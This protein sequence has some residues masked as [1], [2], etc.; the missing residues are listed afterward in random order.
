MCTISKLLPTSWTKTGCPTSLFLLQY[1]YNVDVDLTESTHS[2]PPDSPYLHYQVYY[3]VP[4]VVARVV[5]PPKAVTAC[6]R[7]NYQSEEETVRSVEI[8]Q[9]VS[10]RVQQL[11]INSARYRTEGQRRIISCS[12]CRNIYKNSHSRA[13]W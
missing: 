9:G 7:H 5:H 4:W 6:T 2:D 10:T 12:C 1:I 11:L 3:I 8:N 13:G